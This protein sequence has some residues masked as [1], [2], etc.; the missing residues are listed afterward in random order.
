M[1]L[2]LFGTTGDSA[3][4]NTVRVF[5]EAFD[6]RGAFVTVEETVTVNPKVFS[7]SDLQDLKTS[8]EALQEG[9]DVDDQLG[10]WLLCDI[11]SV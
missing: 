1:F 10:M 4:N 2:Y 8:G 6:K 7:L 9:G 11:T 3:K 5:V